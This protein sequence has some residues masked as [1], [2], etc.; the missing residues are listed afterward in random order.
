MN[1]QS[2]EKEGHDRTS[3][4]LPG[5]QSALIRQVANVSKVVILVILSGGC[6]D[7]SE[8]QS[9]DKVHAIVW[10]GYPGQFHIF[11]FLSFL[12]TLVEHP[13]K[14]MYGGQAI[15]DGIFGAFSPVGRYVTPKS[16][17]TDPSQHFPYRTG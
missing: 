12:R 10:G 6:V 17:R 11:S 4:A 5:A 3:L 9:S 1:A 7:I 13:C 15:V 14:G 2:Q 8:F 16:P